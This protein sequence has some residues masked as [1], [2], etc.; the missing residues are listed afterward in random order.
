MK[1]LLSVA[2]LGSTGYV[3]L[4]LVKILIRHPNFKIKFLGCENS[5]A[6]DIRQFD[7]NIVTDTLPKLE[8]NNNF[9]PN[10]CDLV[11]LSL[12]HGVS[13]TFVK[14]YHNKIHI[15]DLSADFRLDSKY[16]YSKNYNN[17]H[18]CPE[19]LD[20]FIYGLPE[21]NKNK[22]NTNFNIAV[23]GCYPTSVLIPLIPLLEKNLI[24]T[25]NI[26]IDSKSG[27]S[28]AGKKFDKNNIIN[29]LKFNFYNYNTNEHRHICE[30]QQELNKHSNQKVSFSFNPHILPIYR[31]MMSSIYCDLQKNITFKDVDNCLTK[32]TKNLL[33]V[34]VLDDKIRGDFFK[35]QNTNKCLIKLYDQKS[36]SKIIIVSLI[37]NLLKGAAGQAIQCANLMF[38][39]KE[40]IGFY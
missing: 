5:P 35:V 13:H 25:N 38:G 32:F 30:I 23:P 31:G 8:L 9:D 7:K 18:L 36:K 12:P 37:D 34:D 3:G 4:E 2:V 20:Q 27:Y 29:K 21:I 16:I 10:N 39:F 17:D 15:I 28:G 19:L 26:I 33:F 22:I 40:N 1:E 11:F 24:K 14:R 6:K